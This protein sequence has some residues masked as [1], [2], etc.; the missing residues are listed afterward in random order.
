VV[1]MCAVVMVGYTSLN[2]KVILCFGEPMAC[3]L[4][5]S[6]PFPPQSG[7]ITHREVC[8]SSV[9]RFKNLVNVNVLILKR[10]LL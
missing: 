4:A 3:A 1:R 7:R 5:H 10:L 2:T 6:L 8:T 9:P